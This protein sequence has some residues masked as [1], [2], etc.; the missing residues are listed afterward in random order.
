MIDLPGHLEV[1]AS[2]NRW[3]DLLYKSR[4]TSDH[5]LVGTVISKTCSY[6]RRDHAQLSAISNYSI[7]RILNLGPDTIQELINDLVKYGWIYDTEKPIG[8][9]KVYVLTFSLLPMGEPKK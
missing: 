1:V 6:K 2:G 7:G 3:L 4:L 9:R 5:K 8:A